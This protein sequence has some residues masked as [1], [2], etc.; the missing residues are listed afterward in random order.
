MSKRFKDFYVGEPVLADVFYD[1]LPEEYRRLAFTVGNLNKIELVKK[2]MDDMTKGMEKF[3]SFEKWKETVDPAFYET[4][5]EGQ[6]ATVYRTNMSTAFTNGIVEQ[7]QATGISTKYAFQAILD[8]RTRESHA[9]CDG[10]VLPI[11]DPFWLSHT[12]PLGYNCRC[13]IIPLNS[14]NEVASTPKTE[15]NLN[16]TR[17]DKGFGLRPGTLETALNAQFRNSLNDLPSD[18]RVQATTTFATKTAVVNKFMSDN[19]NNFTKPDK[20]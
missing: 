3:E 6:L 10:I 18:L 12:P 9:A 16:E 5:G 11:D 20:T 1:Q 7:S 13:T 2:V 15:I 19:K 4:F 8:D 17:P 14:E